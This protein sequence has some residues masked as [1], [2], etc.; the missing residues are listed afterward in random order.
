MTVSTSGSGSLLIVAAPSGAGKSSLVGALLAQEPD[1]R[2]SISCTTR[3]PRPG[4][5]HGREYFFLSEAEFLERRESGEFL[6][7][8]HVHG[9]Y[10]GTSRV[11]IEE[12]TQ[13]GKDVLLEIDW[14]GARQVR[15][16]FPQAVGIFILPPSVAVLEQRLRSRGQDSDEIIARRVKAADG[17]IA[18]APEFDYVIINDSFETALSQLTAIARAMRCRYRQ[19]AARHASLF[20]DYGIQ[21]RLT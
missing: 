1:I 10:Y 8:A 9:N 18:H 19:Q 13:A 7:S 2:L 15:E 14:Q 4:E 16:Q 11:V 3:A 20:A 12:Q 17:E 6:E 21:P 5:Q